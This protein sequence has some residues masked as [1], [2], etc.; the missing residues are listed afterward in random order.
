MAVGVL[1]TIWKHTVMTIGKRDRLDMGKARHAM[2]DWSCWKQTVDAQCSIQD[3]WD[4]G[5][6]CNTPTNGPKG[7]DLTSHVIVCLSSHSYEHQCSNGYHV[8]TLD[9]SFTSLL[10]MASIK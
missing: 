6:L 8:N 5:M 3:E 10:V 1:I 9:E 7:A 4:K 2:K